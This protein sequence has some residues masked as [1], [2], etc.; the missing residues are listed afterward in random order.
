CARQLLRRLPVT[1]ILDKEKRGGHP[2]RSAEKAELVEELGA[3]GIEGGEEF[4]VGVGLDKGVADLRGDYEAILLYAGD[5]G[6]F[7]DGGRGEAFSEEGGY[8]GRVLVPEA[9]AVGE[10]VDAAGDVEVVVLRWEGFRRRAEG[11]V[12]LLLRRRRR[13]VVPEGRR[14]DYGRYGF[15]GMATVGE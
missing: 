11:L 1:A 8:E 5:A 12:D 9:E 14:V 7:L 6:G 10:D 2:L 15:D 13:A 4:G 3:A